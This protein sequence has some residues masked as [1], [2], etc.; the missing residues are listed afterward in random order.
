MNPSAPGGNQQSENGWALFLRT[1][2]PGLPAVAAQG[3]ISSL[4]QTQLG[5]MYAGWQLRSWPPREAKEATFLHPAQLFLGP[6]LRKCAEAIPPDIAR[7]HK[8]CRQRKVFICVQCQQVNSGQH[9]RICRRCKTYNPTV[10]AAPAAAPVLPTPSE[11]PVLIAPAVKPVLATP[12]EAP[13]LAAP[14]V[15]LFW[16]HLVRHR[17]WLRLLQHRV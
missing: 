3:G 11:A 4:E 14:V 13:G 1:F 12:S 8:K 9:K 15:Y 17:S 2:H 16:L 10:L 5:M 6:L 7:P